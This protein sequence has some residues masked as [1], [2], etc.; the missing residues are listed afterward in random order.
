MK[1]A[2]IATASATLQAQI[3]SID[4]RLELVHAFTLFG[5]EIV[6]D[7]PPHTVDW[8]VPRRLKQVADTPDLRRQRDELLAEA[9]IICITFPF[10][11]RIASRAPRL[12]YLHQIPAGVS[13]L[14]RS[15]L[16]GT[17]IPLSSGRGVNRSLPIAEWV[18]G[19][20]V[21]LMK[22]WPRAFAQRGRGRFDRTELRGLLVAGKTIGIVGLGGIGH[23]VA[24]LAH[25][26][27][28]RVVG[29]NRS[30]GPVDFVERVYGSGDLHA[31]LVESHVVVLTT[32]LTPDTHHLMD[33]AAFDAMR[34]GSFLIN[35]ARG[36]LID[37]AALI[38]ALGCSKLAGFAGDVYESE[39]ER[40]PPAELLAFDNVMLTP[41]TSGHG[42]LPSDDSME[43][44]VENIRRLLAH[45]PL[46]NLVDWARGY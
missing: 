3:T 22:D 12:R 35:V 45:E 27:G 42:D 31:L 46:V 24:R 5:P 43:I 32:Q 9:E 7:W 2:L 38:Q 13:N 4:P 15:D 21:A 29:M 36:E 18:I 28:M 17:S 26:I 30:G 33:M 14:T 44:F 41:H 23:H 20:A 10:P 19:A 39:F 11:T 40:Q 6:A 8:Y 34:N 1:I 16:W 37:E 25:A